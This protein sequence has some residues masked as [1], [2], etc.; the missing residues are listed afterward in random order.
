MNRS[1]NINDDVTLTY[2]L[3]KLLDKV[4]ALFVTKKDADAKYVSK[5][6]D[7]MTGNLTLD[8]TSSASR[9]VMMVDKRITVGEHPS[10]IVY[11]AALRLRD[12]NS[13][14]MGIVQNIYT[15]DGKVALHLGSRQKVGS[16]L[17]QNNITLYT[18]EDGT[19]TVNVTVPSAWR[20]AID[21]VCKTGDT[22]TGNLGI[23]GNG[24]GD[25]Q[26]NL[27]DPIMDTSASS[28]ASARGNIIFLRDKDNRV[29]GAL[30]VS[31]STNGTVSL[32]LYARRYYN[33]ANLNHNLVLSIDKGGN[34]TVTFTDA[35]AWRTGLGLAS[36]T[37]FPPSSWH[38]KITGNAGTCRKYG[39]VIMFNW[40]VKQTGAVASGATL[41][42]FATGTSFAWCYGLIIKGNNLLGVCHSTNNTIV[43]DVAVPWSSGNE[44]FTI[45]LTTSL[46]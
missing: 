38:S 33:N 42:T 10:D 11:G 30:N 5:S 40:N 27:K 15:A 17:Y 43:A 46:L 14:E 36:T 20:N 21:A 39:Q 3:N 37:N 41:A 8:G 24:N 16:S 12:S 13:T 35:A 44:Y 6:G 1:R 45:I 7:T 29:A 4:K 25:T 18:A 26:I 22:M 31:Q 9:S 19:R 34:R 32:Y 23:D 28:I 2:L